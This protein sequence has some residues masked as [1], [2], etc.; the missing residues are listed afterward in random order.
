MP[1]IGIDL[2]TT[3]SLAAVWMDDKCVL[4]PNTLGDY[5]TPSAVSIDED[6]AVLV[7]RTARDRLVSHPDRTA[8]SFK[9]LMGSDTKLTLAGKTFTP[10][11]LSAFVLR[12]LKEDAEAF[13]GAPVT[14]AVIS[15]PAHFDDN[16]RSATKAAGELAGFRVERIINEPS[17]AA[18]AYHKG[19]DEDMT[20][21][22][23]DFGGG[24]LDVS[25]VDAFSNIIETIAVAGD[26]HLGGD[27]FNQAIVSYF[28]KENDLILSD[29]PRETSASLLRQAEQCKIALSS[30]EPVM[31][32][33]EIAG[34]QHTLLLNNQKL[35]NI[36]TPLLRRIEVPIAR[37]LRDCQSTVSEIDEIVL[38]GGS[39]QMPLVQQY[40]HH[41][42]GKPPL[43][44]F[45]T[46]T[47]VAL[48]AGIAAGIKERRS[49]L[50]DTLLTDICPFTLGVNVIN[51]EDPS[52]DLFSPILERNTSLPASRMSTYFT[53]HNNQTKVSIGIY[54]GEGIY[55]RDNLKLGEIEINVPRTARGTQ[56]VDVRLTYDIN[57]ILQ[58]EVT[59]QSTGQKNQTLILNPQF[60]LNEEELQAH[61]AA[62]EQ[63][64]LLPRE[65]EEN[66]VLL[67]RAARLYSESTGM[68]REQIHEQISYFNLLLREAIEPKL[69]RY[70]KELAQ[71]LD[72]IDDHLGSDDE[73]L[74]A[75]REGYD[76]EPYEDD[77]EF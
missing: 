3:N 21:L 59:C 64:K 33:A 27:D 37:A 63:Y 51:H 39:C 62:L 66:K 30:A 28:C 57:G 17:A 67:A 69:R 12:R 65:E 58:I 20:F 2:G 26:N 16:A 1:I 38:V 25:V 76:M 13:L 32:I 29:L 6:G 18:L 23:V 50:R 22:V 73:I 60:R 40:L 72:Q 53:T 31:M 24:T 77:A 45:D 7:G 9:R 10:V 4:I 41:M 52:N 43:H 11:E 5:L 8:A 55:C 71:F 47:T 35:V 14:E 44:E 74:R 68:L 49:A 61:L 46:D 42:L 36:S 19:S 56:G 70:R 48:G 15:V 34:Q 54:Q 75:F